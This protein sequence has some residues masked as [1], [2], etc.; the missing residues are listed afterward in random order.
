[1]VMA[2]NAMLM[3]ASNAMIM[4]MMIE[5]DIK[6]DYL[7]NSMLIMRSLSLSFI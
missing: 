5:V 2:S 4:I 6:A 1:M 3:M 7:L